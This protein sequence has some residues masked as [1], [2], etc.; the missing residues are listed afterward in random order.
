MS[1]V[2]LQGGKVITYDQGNE[3]EEELVRER[4]ERGSARKW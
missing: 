2:G 1:C 4:G 3:R